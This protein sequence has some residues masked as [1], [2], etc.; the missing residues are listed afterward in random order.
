MTYGTEP[1]Y[2]LYETTGVLRPAIEAYL[3]GSMSPG[4]VSAMRAYLWQWI[5]A[6]VWDQNPHATVGDR[7]WLTLLRRRAEDLDSIEAI[8]AWIVDATDFG[9]DPL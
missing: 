9:M 2:W 8:R 3:A 7:A 5:H 6:P 1:H 4:Q